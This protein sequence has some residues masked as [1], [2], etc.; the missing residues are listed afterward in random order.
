MGCKPQDLYVWND[1]SC[2][3]Q[4]SPLPGVQALPLYQ[5]ACDAFVLVE[6]PQYFDRAWCRTE[7]YLQA[8]LGCLTVTHKLPNGQTQ[9][10]R[11]PSHAGECRADR[12]PLVALEGFRR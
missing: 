12:A 4:S 1:F 8:R 6:H 3:D 5:M 11:E 9:V 2:V 7:A 10:Q